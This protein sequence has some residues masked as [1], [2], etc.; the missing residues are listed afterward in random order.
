MFNFE[1]VDSNAINERI[2]A[3]NAK[4]ANGSADVDEDALEIRDLGQMGFTQGE[5]IQIHDPRV[6]SDIVN[7][8]KAYLFV[9]KSSK[10]ASADWHLGQL[11]RRY[12]L[13]DAQGKEQTTN[14]DDGEG[15]VIAGG[16]VI[17]AWKKHKNVG[18]AKKELFVNGDFT[19]PKTIFVSVRRFPLV[20]RYDN[21]TGGQRPGRASLY[22]FWFTNDQQQP[23]DSNGNVVEFNN[24]GT[25]KTASQQG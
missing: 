14:G 18:E 20:L 23:I 1:V 9:C 24:D 13:C 6:K 10:K 3:L 2:T 11:T 4:S 7:G 19:K 22:S 5:L 12:T 16:S 15:H 25:V 21:R 8:Q 17:E